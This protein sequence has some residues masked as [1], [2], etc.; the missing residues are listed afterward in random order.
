MSRWERKGCSPDRIGLP[1]LHRIIAAAVILGRRS[2][3]EAVF[4]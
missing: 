4:R 2:M 1:D 3:Q